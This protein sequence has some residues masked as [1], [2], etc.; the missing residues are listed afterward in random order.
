MAAVLLGAAEIVL[1]VGVGVRG[2]AG[3][4]AHG[5]L[6]LTLQ[7]TGLAKQGGLRK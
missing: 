2:G 6:P 1:V 3:V 5:A 7:D 4:T